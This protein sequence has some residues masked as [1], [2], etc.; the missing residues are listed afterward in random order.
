MTI[1]K[2]NLDYLFHPRT[3]A[4]IGVGNE[5]NRRN[6][7]RGFVESLID[8]G[9]KGKLYPVG[10]DG[11]EIHG[12]KIY[13]SIKDI[14]DSVDYVISAI[15]ARFTTQL[16]LDSA[17]RGVK[18]MH[19]FSAGWGEIADEEG[20]KMELEMTSVARRTGIR[21]IGPNCM[22]I[23]CP[24]TG[25]TCFRDSP[26]QS[27]PFAFISQSGMNAFYI[28]LEGEMRGIYYSKVISYGN[29]T[30]LNESD[31]LEYFAQDPETEVIASYIEGIKDGARFLK[32]LKKAAM[33]K[34]VVLYK[35]GITE[36]GVRATASH[37]GSM[38]GSDKTWDSLL[39]QAGVLRVYSIEELIDML[40][41]FR[42]M[43][44]PT[45][46][47]VVFMGSGGGTVVQ[48]ADE[49][50]EA[51]LNLP[52]LPLEIRKKLEDAYGSETGSSFR[53]PIDM[54]WKEEAI[55]KAVATI[56]GFEGFDLLMVQIVLGFDKDATLDKPILRA[57][58]KSLL[59]LDKGIRQ[60]CAVILR[61]VAAS[62]FWSLTRETQDNL[63]QAG[64]PVFPSASRAASTIAK[65]IEFHR[66]H[67]EIVSQ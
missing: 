66:R 3:I 62:R 18:A 53:N 13:L 61:P 16:L 51:G 19:I 5:T 34:P 11:G 4:V 28:I 20:K 48:S 7:G 24:K 67:K 58:M 35:A 21:I 12:L 64:F 32:V 29:A 56:A 27:G 1:N 26:K 2:P 25:L 14:P 39:K 63:F 37:T 42:Y 60:R 54:F 9:F 52:P 6:A 44:P 36:H 8:I 10:I 22:G 43:S 41:L 31:F 49:C 33:L 50:T 17:G 59:N 55:Q 45:G 47:N 30:D 38:A 57:Y 40:S 65:F 46:K 23:Y 15:P